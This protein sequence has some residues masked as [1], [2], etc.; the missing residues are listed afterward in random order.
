MDIQLNSFFND[1]RIKKRIKLIEENKLNILALVGVGFVAALLLSFILP[2]NYIATSVVKFNYN[3]IS[4]GLL[5]S[6]GSLAKEVELLKSNQVLFSSQRQLAEN[7]LNFE[8]E[9]LLASLEVEEDQAG[10]AVIIIA[11][12]NDGENSAKIANTISADFFHECQLNN[13]SA[14]LSILKVLNDRDGLLQQQL[15]SRAP[16]S[17]QNSLSAANDQTV[18]QIAEFESELEAVEMDN[19]FYSLQFEELQKIIDNKFPEVFGQISI[20]NNP[21][22]KP[23]K[24]KIER[25][26]VQN[27]LINVLQKLRGFEVSYPW[28]EKYDANKLEEYKTTFFSQLNSITKDV[29]EKNNIVDKE[30]FYKLANKY[31]SNQFNLNAVDQTKSVIFSTM[32]SLEDKFNRISF[33]LLDLA[34]EIRTQRFSSNLNQ[35]IKSKIIRVKEQ[36]N[37]FMAEP[38]SIQ[39]AETPESFSSPSVTLNLFLGVLLGLAAGIFRTFRNS[40]KDFDIIESHT[41]IEEAGYKLISQIPHFDSEDSLLF[42]SNIKSEN[43][44]L[45]PKLIHA[46]ENVGAYLKYGNLERPLRT[47]FVTSGSNEEGK[48]VVASNIALALANKNNKVLLVD[49]DLIKPELH[50][51]FRIKSTPS[52]AH[53]LFRK[54]EFEEIIRKTFNKNLDLITCIEFPQNPS[55]IITSERMK[56]FM[57]IVEKDYDYVIYDSSSLYSLKE[58]CFIGKNVDETILV[59]RANSTKFSEISKLETILNENGVVNFDVILNDV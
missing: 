6:S 49:A 34:R 50:K 39:L 38:V 51:I 29:A 58:S 14:Y 47:V 59:V 54:K 25:I 24:E 57:E 28:D 15:K 10:S 44:I 3:S 40:G 7:G 56:N 53:Y 11:N 46:F 35:K 8:V 45:N 18:T 55:I 52:L 13:R 26:E 42:D 4:N 30:H 32:T 31:Y 37:S 33:E 43:E 2:K 16:V 22:L 48:S 5:G 12:S 36:E 23:L 27:N 17:S 21:S 20:L 19:Q 41:E 9:D 1:I